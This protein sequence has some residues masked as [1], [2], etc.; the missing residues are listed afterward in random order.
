M[1][2]DMAEFSFPGRVPAIVDH[3][4]NDFV[5]WEVSR[6]LYAFHC[7]SLPVVD[8]YTTISLLPYSPQRS[9]PT[10]R[11]STILPTS[12]PE[13]L[14]RR[15]PRLLVRPQCQSVICGQ[16]MEAHVL[17]VKRMAFCFT[18]WIAFQISGLGPSQGQSALV[19]DPIPHLSHRADLFLARYIPSFFHYPYIL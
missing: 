16:K 15:R 12:T 7:L 14:W 13:R 6:S 2:I 11:R 9:S 3:S 10:L 8:L 18:V 1:V 17:I 4:N 19:S 5:V